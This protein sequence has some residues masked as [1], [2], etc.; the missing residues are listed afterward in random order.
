MLGVAAWR[1]SM[2]NGKASFRDRCVTA[3]FELRTEEAGREQVEQRERPLAKLD[4]NR[5]MGSGREF[6]RPNCFHKRDLGSGAVRERR[7]REQE[8]CDAQKDGSAYAYGFDGRRDQRIP[9]AAPRMARPFRAGLNDVCS[10]LSN[11]A[12]D[13]SDEARLCH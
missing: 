12:G 1:A 5:V 6:R 11:L 4:L 7:E 13:P 8:C 9:H 3:G 10:M 2:A